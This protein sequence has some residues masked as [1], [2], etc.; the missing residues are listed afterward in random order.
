MIQDSHCRAVGHKKEGA[1]Y[2][3]QGPDSL[4]KWKMEEKGVLLLFSLVSGKLKKGEIT[5][6]TGFINLILNRKLV[7]S[8]KIFL[9][10]CFVCHTVATRQV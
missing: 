2:L 8:F 1:F 10:T 6:G 5:H 7:Y 4:L 3:H 9:N